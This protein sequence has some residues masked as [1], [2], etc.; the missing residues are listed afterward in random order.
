MTRPGQARVTATT[1][2]ENPA[3]IQAGAIPVSRSVRVAMAMLV[4]VSTVLAGCA[5]PGG[6]NRYAVSIQW[7]DTAWCVPFR[8][9]TV[10]RRISRRYGPVRV[11]STHRWLIENWI[12]GGKPRS[13]HLACKAVDFSVRGDPPGVLTFL[14]AQREVGGYARYKQGF[15]H[16]DTGPRRTW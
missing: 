4:V 6:A 13:Y 7:N 16:I 15:Y 5:T 12:K 8:L 10:L 11:H 1:H 3:E 9:K 14:K 2:D